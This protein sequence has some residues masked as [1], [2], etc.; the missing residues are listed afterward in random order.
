L[1]PSGEDEILVCSGCGYS[2]NVEKAVG[3][4]KNAPFNSSILNLKTN[5]QKMKEL[6]VTVIATIEC[7]VDIKFFQ[8]VSS[9]IVIIV[10]KKRILNNVKLEKNANLK[11]LITCGSTSDGKLIE[12]YIDTHVLLKKKL[13]YVKYKDLINIEDQ[14]ICASCNSTLGINR[15][16][17]V[18]HTFYLGTKYSATLDAT[19]KTSSQ[20]QLP[21][22]MG[23]YGIGVS[24]LMAAVIEASHDANGIIWPKAI[25]P[26]KVC[27]ICIPTDLDNKLERV[28][29]DSVFTAGQHLF[30][31]NDIIIDD[32]DVSFG[33][34]MKDAL[35][36]GYPLVIVA[37]KIFY[38]NGYL[39][40]HHRSM[41]KMKIHCSELNKYFLDHG[42]Q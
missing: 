28:L 1:S 36:I 9:S 2:A 7:D 33:F 24:R 30:E 34:K 21:F 12:V 17:E 32:R 10:P 42:F 37:G 11:S 6:L 39:E 27:L 8:T 16:I 20:K 40:V 26:Y 13:D 22:Q 4:L 41:G 18:A 38:E 5:D 14:D 23:C 3:L 35:L 29:I 25:A 15:A 31:E 19:F